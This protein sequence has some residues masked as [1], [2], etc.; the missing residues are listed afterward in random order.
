MCGIGG[1]MDDTIDMRHQQS[2]LQAMAETLAK[3]GPDD[4]GMFVDAHIGMVHRR[5][6]ILDPK[7]GKQPMIARRGQETF[8]ISYNG[9]I[10]NFRELKQELMQKGYSFH[11]ETDTEVL[12]NGY[13]EWGSDLFGRLHGICAIAIYEAHRKRLILARDKLGVKP[14]FYY[15]YENGI[16]FGSQLRTLLAHPNVEP[17]LDTDGFRQIFLLGPGRIPGEGII[18]GVKEVLPGEMVTF[19]QD[20]LKKEIYWKLQAKPHVET[21]AE[22]I[23]HTRQ[24]VR[25][26]VKSQLQSD[27][28]Y[29]TMLSGGLDS[30]IVTKFASE[31][32]P[33]D[34]FYVSYQ[35]ND[36]Y[37]QT[38][39]FQPN[40]DGD[41]I[42]YMVQDVGSHNHGTVINNDDLFHALTDAMEARD[43]PGMADVDASLYLFCQDIKRHQSVVLS[44]ECADEIFGGYPWYHHKEI[45]ECPKFPW[46]NSADLR[47]SMVKEGLLE[48]GDAYLDH[49]YR[50]TIEQT[51]YLDTDNELDIRMRRMMMLNLYWFMQTLLD[52]SDR[53]SMA[54]GL[55]LRVPFCDDRL[56]EYCFN[57]PWH[58]KSLHG[59]EKG[60]LREA[61]RGIL[62]DTI[63]DRKKSPYP[64]THHP[65]YFE[66]VKQRV[67]EIMEEDGLLAYILDHDTVNRVMQSAD[68]LSS[69]FYGQLM[70]APQLLAYLIQVDA[71][72]KQYHIRIER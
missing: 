52:R 69:P 23:A 29:G 61:M 59:R 60:I 31:D 39:L 49:L 58:L 40:Q 4:E 19:D 11:T 3:R 20:G 25:D 51:P 46:T 36:K 32:G 63:I 67:Q 10:Y 18:R 16:I 6:S 17:I 55:E 34:T 5:L 8:V 68:A 30:S 42:E 26:C 64:K 38:S 33:I 12:L 62:P 72:F 9:Q 43:L 56:V 50:K 21:E 35:D 13:M 54:H 57:M 48:N 65:H 14:L 37:F 53:M 2:V 41:F 28:G 70:K 66:L 24:L 1:W 71:W 44:G 7:K 27:V 15:S 22:T 47:M 45:Y